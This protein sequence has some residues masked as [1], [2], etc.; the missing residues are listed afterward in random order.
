MTYRLTN[1]EIE[2]KILSKLIHTAFGLG[3]SISVFDGEEETLTKSISF[4]EVLQAIRTTDEDTLS[5]HSPTEYV[6][7]VWLF[8]GSG[9]DVIGD[10]TDNEK[11]TEL[12][13]P[14]MALSV[15]LEDMA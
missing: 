5:F 2:L 1:D 8:Y 13:S 3:Y 15:E 11:M 9:V 10:S 14:A 12:L 6:G 4:V 7:R